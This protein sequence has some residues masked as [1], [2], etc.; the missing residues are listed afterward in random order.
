MKQLILHPLVFSLILLVALVYFVVLFQI[1]SHNTTWQKKVEKIFIVSSIL[2]IGGMKLRF[3]GRFHPQGLYKPDIS[4]SYRVMCLSFYVPFILLIFSRLCYTLKDYIYVLSILIKNSSFFAGFILWRFIA[5]ILSETPSYTLKATIVL[6]LITLYFVY[7]GKQYTMKELL[8]LLTWHNGIVM[9]LSLFHG[10]DGNWNG[11]YLSKNLF[12]F[13]MAITAILFYLQSVRVPK[14]RLLFLSLSALA[15]FCLQQAN[16]GMA[17]VLLIVLISL[18]VFL[19]FIKRLPP[20][21]AFASMGGFIAI[22]ISLV[23]FITE[24][25]EYIIVEKLGKDM[26]LTGRTYIWREVIKA[27][28]KHPLFGYGYEGFWQFWRGLDNPALML[29]LPEFHGF[30]PQHSHSGYFEIA[31]QVGWVGLTLFIVSLLTGIY[32]GV[33]YLT[34][35]QT[36]EAVLPLLLLTWIVIGSVTEAYIKDMGIYWIVYVL[37]MTRLSL[38]TVENSM[39]N[40]QIQKQETQ[41]STWQLNQSQAR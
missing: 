18:L 8:I 21:V 1:I 13:M 38:D 2:I 22:G 3:S 15:V 4:L 32:Y 36:P 7:V 30:I 17:K 37:M 35:N 31:L 27:I 11:I 33:L 14:Y 6:M 20:R 5:A 16:S 26:T 10:T 24:N 28:N 39:E 29:R 23:I 34:R 12:G 19:R 9:L 40:R 25:A 41:D